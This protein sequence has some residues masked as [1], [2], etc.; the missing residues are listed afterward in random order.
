MKVNK[1]YYASV[2]GA[3]VLAMAPLP[4]SALDVLGFS[5]ANDLVCAFDPACALPRGGVSD[6]LFLLLGGNV[7]D[8]IIAFGNEEADNFYYFNP[9]SVPFDPASTGAP[10][11]LAK[12]DGTFS[13]VFGALTLGNLPTA[14]GF[15][16]DPFA[17]LSGAVFPGATVETPGV[18]FGLVMEP[19]SVNTIPYDATAY[20]DPGMRN[21]GYAAFFYSSFDLSSPAHAPEIDAAAGAGA[22]TLLV[23]SLAVMA[24]RSRRTGGKT[25]V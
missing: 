15:I 22:L 1:K 9:I 20:L 21:A 7:V 25:E 13:D 6:G 23:G 4:A 3:G 12:P 17:G 18:S 11:F 24:E 16:S 14:L 2:V 19:G 8:A 10:T 5:T